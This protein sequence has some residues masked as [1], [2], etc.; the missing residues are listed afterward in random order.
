MT[1]KLHT[2]AGK[3]F[4]TKTIFTKKE[5]QYAVITDDLVI[6]SLEWDLELKV[7]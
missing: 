4:H 2:E 3:Q 1:L 7:K 5:K 6:S